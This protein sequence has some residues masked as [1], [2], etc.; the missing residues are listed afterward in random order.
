MGEL[1]NKGTFTYSKGLDSEDFASMYK[2]KDQG[3]L[4]HST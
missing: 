2:T 4:G 3:S 1:E